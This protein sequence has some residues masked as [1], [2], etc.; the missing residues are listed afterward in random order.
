MKKVVF[1][2]TL[3]AIRKH[4][5][6]AYGWAK[7][8]AAI[9]K[10][11]ADNEPINLL[12]ILESNGVQDMLWVL[13]CVKHPDLERVARLMACDFAEAVLSIFEKK[14][15]DDKRPSNAIK[16]ARRYANGKA[17]DEELVAARA[18]A[19]AAARAAAWAAAG[20]A[21]GAAARAA[22]WAAAGAA[23]GAAAWAAA[24][25]AAGA[26]ARAAAWE[27]QARIVRKYLK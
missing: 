22:A 24:W 5:P 21:A 14:Y 13:Q 23:A 25:A 3:N 20:A 1:T 8:L 18:A 2:T 9:G 26:A 19:G 11:K 16:T 27:E 12:T 4:Q 15:P 7:L 6:C 17:T 10:K